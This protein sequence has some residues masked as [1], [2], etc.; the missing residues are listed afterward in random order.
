MKLAEIQSPKF[1]PRLKAIREAAGITQ[2]EL[3]ERIGHASSVP[4]AELEAGRRKPTWDTLCRLADALGVRLDDF[5][6]KE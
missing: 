2:K 6:S 4:V 1:G 3:G 5:R